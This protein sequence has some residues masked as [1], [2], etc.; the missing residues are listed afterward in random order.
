M[1]EKFL[2]VLLGYVLFIILLLI[3]AGVIHALRRRR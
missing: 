1:I 2:L 3:A